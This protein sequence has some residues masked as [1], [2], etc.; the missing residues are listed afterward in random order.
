[1]RILGQAFDEANRVIAH[2]AYG[3]SPEPRQTG[4]V[5]GYVRLY[6]LPESIDGIIDGELFV[7]PVLCDAHPLPLLSKMREGSLPKKVY[8]AHFSPPS[9]LSNKNE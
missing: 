8:L 6:Q 2:I 3:A 9:T 7:L 4:K 5:D 1:M